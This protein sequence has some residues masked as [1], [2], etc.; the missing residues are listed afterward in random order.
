MNPWIAFVIGLSVG[1]MVGVIVM[2][3]LIAAGRNATTARQHPEVGNNHAA[4]P[5][6]LSHNGLHGDEPD[7]KQDHPL[8]DAAIIARSWEIDAGRPPPG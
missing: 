5:R 1:S 4:P 3:T 7:W 2:G 8:G 6:S